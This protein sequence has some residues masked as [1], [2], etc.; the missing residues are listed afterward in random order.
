VKLEFDSQDGVAILRPA[1]ALIGGR[2]TEE[3]EKKVEELCASGNDALLINLAKVPY[4]T[5]PSIGALVKAYVSYTKRGAQMR[6]CGISD[7][8]NKI[9]IVTRLNL[10]FGDNCNQ[11]EE[12]ALASLRRPA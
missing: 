11:T 1:G 4:M 6:M 2:E 9:L 10:V 3:F 7:R 5:T 8:I 12:E